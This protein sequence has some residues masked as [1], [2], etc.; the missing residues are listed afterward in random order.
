MTALPCGCCEP[1]E[2]LTPLERDN[3]GGLSAVAY[4]AG[5]YASFRETMLD[6]IADVPELARL[7][8]REDDDYAVTVIDLWAAVADVLTFYEERYANEAYLRTATQ[9]ASI[10]RLARLIDYSLRPGVAALAWL[11]FTVDDGKTLRVPPRLRVQSVP[12]QD[13]QPQIFETLEEIAADARLSRLRAL[14]AP[15]GVNPLAPGATQALIAPG[16][17]ALAAARGLAPGSAV[18]LY[19]TGAAG[20][21]EEL[22]VAAADAVEDRVTISWQAAIEGS[23]SYLTPATNVGRRFRVFGQTAPESSMSPATDSTVPGGISW[24]LV[25]TDFS[26]GGGPSLALD[27]RVDGI[28]VGTR[29]L[30]DDAAG[31]TSLVTVT[32]V[33]T[34]AESLGGLTDTVTVLTV[35]PGLPASGDRRKLTIYEL[36]GP[37]IPLW[38]YAYPERLAGGSL[39]LPGRRLGDGSIEVGRSITRFQYQPGVQLSVADVAPRRTV[40]VGDPATPPVAA[41]VQ[42]VAVVGSTV[43]VEATAADATTAVELGLDPG[44]AS[45][46]RGL[47][48]AELPSSLALSSATPKLRATMGSLPVRTITLTGAVS[49]PAS[50]ARALRE[51]LAAAGPEPDWAGTVVVRAERS[52]LVFASPDQQG[53]ELTA[54]ADDGTTVRELGL[55]LDQVRPMGALLSGP[56]S[57][58]PMFS[59]STPQIGMTIGPVGPR[60]VSVTGHPTLGSLANALQHAVAAADPAPGFATARVLVSGHRLLVVPG[61]LSGEITEYLRIDVATDAPLDLDAAGAYLLGNVAA[62]SHGETVASEIVGDGDAS[63][64][65][66]R[67]ALKKQPLTYVPSAD[68]GG[69]DSTLELR[70]NGVLWSEVPGLYGEPSTAQVYAARTREDGAT[71]VQFGDGSTGATL[72][73]GQANVTATYRVGAGV[74]GRVRAGTLTSPLDRPPGLKAVTNP[75]PARGGAD[76]ESLAGARENAPSTVRTFGRAVSLLDFA[77][78][79]RASGEVAKAQATWVWDGFDHAVELTVAG[80]AG[81]SFDEEDLRRLGAALAAAREPDYR[82]LL[83]NYRALPIVLRGSIDVDARYVQDDV[84]ASV[85]TAVLAA[86][87]FDALDLGTAVHLSE[88]YRVI[89][90]VDGVVAADL[91]ELQPKRPADRDRPNVDRMADGTPAPLQPHVRVLPARPDP[92]HPGTVLPAEL[93][94]IEDPARDVTL[95]GTGGGGA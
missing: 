65:F 13:E 68:P 14:P 94:T 64:S 10:M 2:P 9:A 12:G 95:T 56:L 39:F 85:R 77:D 50:A 81:G 5:T 29:L 92:L 23:W 37:D 62:A 75:L 3:R 72:P 45:S 35:S 42:S 84:V 11:A 4:R 26:L 17:A 74:A 61:P 59:A 51:A 41:T 63:A 70:A 22:K 48:G 69:V 54:A 40:L 28:A 43:Q 24:S 86:L 87:S 46:L 7:T 18:V 90:D 31:A 21:V 80:Q 89:Q 66:Q 58:P 91:D 15:F 6:Q 79:V 16:D 19:R 38:A 8:T 33:T 30:V 47:I 34:G 53:I 32:G 82:V 76:P 57:T 71:V 88:V 25:G 44:D 83:D 67:L 36:V 55:D 27:A 52:L 60:T 1:L 78:L 93:A 73:T 49:T 20:V